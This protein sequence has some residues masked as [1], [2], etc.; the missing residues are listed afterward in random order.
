MQLEPKLSNTWIGYAS[1]L[2]EVVQL[3]IPEYLGNE[4][5]FAL[6]PPQTNVMIESI[7]PRPLTQK[8]LTRCLNQSSELITFF[9]IRLLVLAFEK[10]R[11]RSLLALAGRLLAAMET[12]GKKHRTAC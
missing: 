9:A 7:L 4:N 6:L 8:V 11:V 3:P 2:F 1:F 10:M 5:E 12:C